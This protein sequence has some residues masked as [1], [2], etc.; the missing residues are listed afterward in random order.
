MRF[1]R[2]PVAS[3]RPGALAPEHWGP[4]APA[5][6][7]PEPGERLDVYGRL[8]AGGRPRFGGPRSG[9]RAVTERYREC[10]TAAA[11]RPKRH[12]GCGPRPAVGIIGTLPR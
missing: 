2:L 7:S 8:D 4:W 10:L 12:A 3:P 5:P 6:G 9:H 11:G 1:P